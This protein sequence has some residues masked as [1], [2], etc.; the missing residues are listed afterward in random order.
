MVEVPQN[1]M[2]VLSVK[3]LADS[4]L[5]TIIIDE[6]VAVEAIHAERVRKH[7]IQHLIDVSI[8]DDAAAV[9]R[10][11]LRSAGRVSKCVL[12]LIA[13]SD[14]N[15][16]LR[17]V[18]IR[19]QCAVVTGILL[20]VLDARLVLHQVLDARLELLEVAHVWLSRL[21]ALDLDH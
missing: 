21:C 7:G 4:Q 8:H 20:L 11:L 14:R 2:A 9:D 16:N 17:L 5:L 1:E 6:A 12:D 10:C 3:G 18:L 19:R 13:A 15:R